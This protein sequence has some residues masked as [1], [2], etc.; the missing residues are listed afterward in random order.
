MTGGPAPSGTTRPRPVSGLSPATS[1]A[2]R[3]AGL[4]PSEVT[5]I[6]SRALAEDL[7]AQGDITSAATVPE[8]AGC[9]VEV[10]PRAT[11]TLAGMPVLSAVADLAPGPVAVTYRLDDGTRV[12]AGRSVARLTGQTRAVLAIERTALNLLG[13]LSG[14][15]TGTAAWV[16]EIAGTAARIRDTRKTVPGLRSLQKYAVRCGGGV[17]HR[18][19]LYDAVLIKDNHVAAAGGVEPALDAALAAVHGRR[20]PI[21]VEVDDLTQLAE[22]VAHGADEVLLDN[23][24]LV[25]LRAAVAL[26]RAGGRA[27]TLEASGGLRLADARQVA[28]TGVDL[29]AVGAL[30]HSA[31]QLDI[32]LDWVG[33]T[34]GGSSPR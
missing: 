27:I 20:V 29:L 25:S 16:A 6:V 22:A 23:F 34:S 24:D 10:V 28:E 4:D 8:R 13:Q 30:T 31:A 2:L 7:G 12:T 21:Q 32:G 18:T 5:G 14:V 19:G 11:G 3:D 33:P 15:A 17:N 9:T 26:V 1:A